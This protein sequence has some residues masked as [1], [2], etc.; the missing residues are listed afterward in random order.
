M[1]LKIDPQRKMACASL[2]P[3]QKSKAG[4]PK[5]NQDHDDDDVDDDDDDG[6]PKVYQDHDDDDVVGIFR[7][8]DEKKLIL[9]QWNPRL[10]AKSSRI[11]EKL[12]KIIQAAMGT[13]LQ[14]YW[15][16]AQ[17]FDGSDLTNIQSSL[18]WQENI[19][20]RRKRRQFDLDESLL[21]RNKKKMPRSSLS[22]NKRCARCLKRYTLESSGWGKRAGPPRM[23]TTVGDERKRDKRK[24]RQGQGSSKRAEHN[25]KRRGAKEPDQEAIAKRLRAILLWG[26][27]SG[28]ILGKRSAYQETKDFGSIS[29]K[30]SALLDLKIAVQPTMEKSGND[31]VF[32]VPLSK[33]GWNLGTAWSLDS[34]GT[35]GELGEIPKRLRAVLFWGK[36]SRLILGQH[37]LKENKLFRENNLAAEAKTKKALPPLKNV[38]QAVRTE[39]SEDDLV[40]VVPL[41]GASWNFDYRGKLRRGNLFSERIRQISVSTLLRTCLKFGRIMAMQ[42]TNAIPL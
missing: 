12:L 15:S 39:K 41:N 22:G 40:F 32:M 33:V 28:L 3:L 10:E 20:Q 26:K 5:V 27:L 14:R 8:N 31:L 11:T 38:A 30:K 6:L 9:M 13:K 4:L 17:L 37:A 21:S 35:S 25:K 2:E 1:I 29:R 7:R 19:S 23:F 18:P 24:R 36:I 16:T 34:S 42:Q